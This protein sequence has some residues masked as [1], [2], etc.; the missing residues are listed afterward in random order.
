MK[1]WS[2]VLVLAVV[3]A[4]LA[5]AAPAYAQG[6]ESPAVFWGG[7]AD[8]SGPLHGY[9]VDA[10]AEALELTAEELESRISA[11]ETLA[12]IAADQ[13]VAAEDLSALWLEAR[14]SALDAAVADGVI[15]AEQADWMLT[16]MQYGMHGLGG[17]AGARRQAGMMG[18]AGTGVCPWA[19]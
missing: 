15:T 12:A 10:F 4:A 17:P 7:P 1:K 2:I 19:Q 16:R 3:L 8:G 14:Q 13:G 6:S 11:G 18:G 5:A 9:L